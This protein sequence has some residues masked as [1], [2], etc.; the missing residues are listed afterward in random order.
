MNTSTDPNVIIL[1]SAGSIL[2]IV[3]VLV[4]IRART[5]AGAA[6][7]P[8]R[9]FSADERR[10]GF[11]R[12]SQQCEF[13]RW[14][15]FRCTRTAIHGDHFLPWSRGGAT[16]MANFVAACG[17]CNVTKGAHI[18]SRAARALMAARRRRYFPAGIPNTAGEW[19]R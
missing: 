2:A 11:E 5:R 1:A 6:T 13:A 12:A 3:C 16:S 9:M 7:D 15:V 4:I 14:V 19:Y 8:R 17:T 10:R 18:P